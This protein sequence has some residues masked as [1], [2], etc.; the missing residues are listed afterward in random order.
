MTSHILPCDHPAGRLLETLFRRSYIIDNESAFLAA[1][2]AVQRKQR[3]SLMRV[4]T[5]PMLPGYVFKVFFMD[6]RHCERK[7][8]RGWNGFARRCD[9]AERIR[10][11]I[12]DRRIRHFRVPR[13]WLFNA[14][15]HP[16]CGPDEQPVVLVADFQDL[17]PKHEN[18]HAWRH[19][20]TPGHLD[21]LYAIIEGAGGVSSRP[22]NIALT[23]LG[24]FAFIDTDHSTNL[25]DYESIA[26]YLS[27]HMRQYWSSLTRSAA[28]ER[29]TL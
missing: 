6:E 8:R 17:V 9:Q 16:S 3:R 10:G 27:W 7:K 2:F 23:R 22:D 11:V 18:E 19:S 1:G 24:W 29:V 13:K 25:H 14:P 12:H 28:T 21:E 5:H 26:P 20:I 4:A 15:H